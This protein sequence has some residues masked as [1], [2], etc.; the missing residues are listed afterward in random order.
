MFVDGGFEAARAVIDRTFGE[1]LRDADPAALGKDAKTRLQEWLQARRLPV[2][3][4]A[5]A[6]VSGEAHAQ[7]FTA[8]CSIAAL[9]IVTHGSGTSRRSAEQA[10]AEAA[11]Q[12]VLARP[13][14]ERP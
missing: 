3:D 12:A 8:A 2:P 7:T 5:I 13:R 14:R 10:A 9:S 1:V 4:Y 6:E 11:L